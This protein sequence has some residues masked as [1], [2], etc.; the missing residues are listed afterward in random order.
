IQYGVGVVD[1]QE[2]FAATCAFRKLFKQAAG[3]GERKMAD[4]SRGFL[5]TARATEFVVGPECAVDEDNIGRSS[6]LGPFGIAAGERGGDEELLT[7]L[8]EEGADGGI[9]GGSRAAGFFADEGGVNAAGGR[10]VADRG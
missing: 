1:V 8:L 3:A 10:G 7:A 2:D 5:A 4:L 6:R 9:V